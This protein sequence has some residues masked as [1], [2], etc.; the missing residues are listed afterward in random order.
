MKKIKAPMI[1]NERSKKARLDLMKALF[2]LSMLVDLFDD[3]AL[4]NKAII[5]QADKNVVNT[6]KRHFQKKFRETTEGLYDLE[7]ENDVDIL[8]P[9]KAE[10][11]A[12]MDRVLAE[13]LILER[14]LDEDK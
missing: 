4:S 7:I 1:P 9:M 6:F 12:I 13:D 8:D 5:R 3:I 10:M 2:K 14:G 11:E